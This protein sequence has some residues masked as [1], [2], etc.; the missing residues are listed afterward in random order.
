MRTGTSAETQRIEKTQSSS[1]NWAWHK[2]N[3]KDV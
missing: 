1:W 3:K 2:N